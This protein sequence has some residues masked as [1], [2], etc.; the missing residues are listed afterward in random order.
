MVQRLAARWQ[1][2]SCRCL[3]YILPF[4]SIL[5]LYAATTPGG[6]SYETT[7]LNIESLWSG[8]PFADPVCLCSFPSMLHSPHIAR[9]QT[10][11]GGNKQPSE[12]NTMAQALED[13]RQSI[14]RSPTGDIDSEHPSSP[15]R[16]SSVNNKH[17]QTSMSWLLTQAN[18]VSST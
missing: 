3:S 11:N 14:F 12:Q 4:R 7:Q 5:I 6:M 13:I 16:L 9:Y 2:I 15:M 10:Y 17:F 1:W 18:M 8:G